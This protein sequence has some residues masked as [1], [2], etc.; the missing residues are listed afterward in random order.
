MTYHCIGIQGKPCPKDNT[1][2]NKPKDG[3]YLCDYCWSIPKRLEYYRHN[4]EKECIS[5]YEIADLQSLADYIDPSDVLLLEWARVPEGEKRIATEEYT[6]EDTRLFFVVDSIEDNEKIFTTL[7]QAREWYAKLKQENKPRIYVALVENAYYDEDLKSW[8]YEDFS[9]TFEIIYM[10]EP[11]EHK[12]QE[13]YPITSICRE[14]L[15]GLTINGK[16]LTQQDVDSIS[17]AHMERLA[18]KMSD[19]YS[20]G[21]FWSDASII[22]ENILTK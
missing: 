13:S 4:I 17:N 7:A 11:C 6:D 3:E 15:V 16:Q 1:T 9:N 18:S 14:D 22:L 10:I 8:N 12:R 20:D 5:S 2:W 19:S 21:S